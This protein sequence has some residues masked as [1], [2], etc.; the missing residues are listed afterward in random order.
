M[1]QY[2]EKHLISLHHSETLLINELS[3]EAEGR[4]ETIYKFGFG[5]SPFGPPPI[6]IETLKEKA[7]SHEYIA[8]QGLPALREAIANCHQEDVGFDLTADQ[9][10]IGPGSKMLIYCALAAFKELSL[11]LPNPTWVSYE[12]QAKLAGHDVV[13][14]NCAY[15]EKWRLTPEKLQQASDQC[16]PNQ[17]KVLILT[18]PGNPDGLTYTP[19]ELEGLATVARENNVIIIS[20]EIYGFLN[21]QGDHVSISKYYPEGTIVTT[22]LSKWCGS[23]GWRLGVAL[24]PESLGLAYRQTCIGIA[25][26]TYSSATTPVQYAAIQAYQ[27]EGTILAYIQ[28]QR[29]ILK[30]VGGWSQQQLLDV[31][32]RVHAPEGGFYLFLDFSPFR[33]QFRSLGVTTN[34]EMTEHLLKETQVALLSGDCFGMDTE[35]LTCRLAY[36]EFDGDDALNGS[37]NIDSIESTEKSIERY[38]PKVKEGIGKLVAWL[39][40]NP[41]LN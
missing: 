9:I 19:S 29:D 23:G 3:R 15:E 24:I 21:H 41:P 35:S 22:G 40:N 31:G 7:T 36:V 25:S 12:P 39:T 11:I 14:V 6:V 20:D 5:Q 28:R 13:R 34:T 26:E 16:K 38:C 30:A 18:Y 10:L 37:F 27:Q 33:E 1:K 32:V 2:V 8:V 17:P 4:G